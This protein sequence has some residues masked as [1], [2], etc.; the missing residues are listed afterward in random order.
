MKRISALLLIGSVFAIAVFGI[1]I[2][3]HT[4]AHSNCIAALAN[5]GICPENDPAGYINFHFGAFQGISK[6]V[7]G[8]AQNDAGALFALI[9]LFT[10]VASG[11][12][13]DLL[14][15]RF[16][17]YKRDHVDG[18]SPPVVQESIRWLALHEVSPTFA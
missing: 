10:L 3:G 13:A 18:F 15:A 2:V 8:H 11:Y 16:S 9:A 4:A 5:Q 1:F 6:G 14:F 12:A 7:L 17:Y